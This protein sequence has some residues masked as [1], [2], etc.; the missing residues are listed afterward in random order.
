M[1]KKSKSEL[2][3]CI[4]LTGDLNAHL[5]EWY[6]EDDNFGLTFQR[7]FNKHGISQLIH[8]PTFLTNKA[9]T[10]IDILATDQPNLVLK[11]EVHPSLHTNCHH[12]VIY[13]KINILIVLLLPP[14]LDTS[15]IIRD[16]ILTLCKRL[17]QIMFGT[18]L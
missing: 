16:P 11:S 8:E 15:G 3:H 7:I 9:K 1:L 17:V 14:I 10:C 2:P 12:Q 13:S 6:G 18:R 4:I 5:R